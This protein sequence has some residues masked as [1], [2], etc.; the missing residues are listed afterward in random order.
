V[1]YLLLSLFVCTSVLAA[2]PKVKD[3]SDQSFQV[4]VRPQV[5]SIQ[6]DLKQVLE[7]FP[8]YPSSVFRN[9]ETV[10]RLIL[11]TDKLQGLC[12]NR[13]TIN[14]L[15]QL[16]L[17]IEN[18]RILER[19]WLSFEAVAGFNTDAT[20]GGISGRHRWLTL[21]EVAMELKN[22][23][24]VETMV[25]GA[26]RPHTAASTWDVRKSIQTIENMQD[27]M[28][29]DFIPGRLQEDFR[30]AW[31]NFFRPLYKRTILLGQKSFV[32]ENLTKLNFYWNLLNM[33][34]TKRL[35]RTPEGMV[36]PLNAIQNRW[37]QI[38]RIYFG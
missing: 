10:D 21:N 8:G 23:L 37:N 18:L 13:L 20:I 35:R 16:N 36:G 1:K 14:C 25:I 17:I 38:L 11:L 15:A 26:D 7:S 22:K 32:T 33:K 31:M 6:D 2:E 19:N 28:V 4:H 29:I 3:I 9:Q 34:L 5:M 27:L 30:Q 12:P 24:E